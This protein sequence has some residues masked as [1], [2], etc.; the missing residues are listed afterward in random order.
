MSSVGS[1]YTV[2]VETLAALAL[3]P[4][5]RRESSAIG[6][7]ARNIAWRIDIDVATSRGERPSRDHICA[8]YRAWSQEAGHPWARRAMGT[9]L[10][11]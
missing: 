3:V 1:E 11:W 8:K 10:L 5:R 7:Y 2:T 9:A 4:G 6:E